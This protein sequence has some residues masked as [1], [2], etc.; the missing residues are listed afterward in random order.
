MEDPTTPPSWDRDH[1]AAIQEA[2][3]VVTERSRGRA[4]E[5]TMADLESELAARGAVAPSRGWLESVARSAEMG[6]V[7]VE[8]REAV[9]D[10][11]GDPDHI[12]RAA[13]A[14]PSGVGHETDEGPAQY[15]R[16]PRDVAEES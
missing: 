2:I 1:K 15:E 12:E 4:I 5:D 10:A 9:I 3:F 14:E 13:T 11:G 7:Y 16:Q 8:S 6:S